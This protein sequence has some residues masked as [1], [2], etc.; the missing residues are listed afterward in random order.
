MLYLGGEC[1]APVLDSTRHGPE[2][3]PDPTTQTSFTIF[4]NTVEIN[5]A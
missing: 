1:H 3:E 2:A 5:V 4:S